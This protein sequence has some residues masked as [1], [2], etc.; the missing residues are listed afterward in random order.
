MLERMHG[1]LHL[2]QTCLTENNTKLRNKT[3]QK[4]KKVAE[5]FTRYSWYMIRKCDV[6]WR[7]LIIA[8]SHNYL[9]SVSV[10]FLRY[11]DW[12]TMY[13]QSA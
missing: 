5:V 8:T 3:K 7:K 6:S 13:F 1:R 2:L 9:S 12:Y 11:N 4:N 10:Y